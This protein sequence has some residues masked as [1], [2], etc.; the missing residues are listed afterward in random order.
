M[1]RLSSH[2]FLHRSRIRIAV[3]LS[4]LV[5]QLIGAFMDAPLPY[6][7]LLWLLVAVTFIWGQID[8]YTQLRRERE[9]RARQ[10]N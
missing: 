9:D 4:S 6:M 1:N 10:W 8:L 5:S 3:Y 2:G 7:G